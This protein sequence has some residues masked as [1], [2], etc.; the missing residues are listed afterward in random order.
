MRVAIISHSSIHQRQ[1]DFYRELSKYIELFVVSP[2]Y[3]GNL[4]AED[5]IEGNLIFKTFITYNTGNMNEFLFPTYVYKHLLRFKPDIVYNL[6]ELWCKQ[7]NISYKW[8]KQLNAKFVNFVWDNIRG[9]EKIKDKLYSVNPDLIIAGNPEAREL[10]STEI[11]LPQVGINTAIFRPKENE[12]K[13]IDVIYI[14]RMVEEKGINYIKEAYPLTHFI[15]GVDYGELPKYYNPSKIFCSY[16]YD[17]E[18]WKE[19]FNYSIGE[20]LACGCIVICSDAGSITSVYGDSPVIIIPQRNS[21]ILKEK[22]E[23]VLNNYSNML[24]IISKGA[25]FIKDNY[26]NEIVS[27]KLVEIFKRIGGKN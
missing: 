16:P 3:W 6:N 8:A 27:K 11:S 15:N 26:S 18:E 24:D 7:T 25:D 23:Y 5:F 1:I 21:L 2:K 19:Q 4:H 13:M 17:T 10:Y 14:G 22:I 20:A 12:S 9:L